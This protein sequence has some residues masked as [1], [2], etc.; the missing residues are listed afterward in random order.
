[1][2]AQPLAAAETAAQYLHLHHRSSAAFIPPPLAALPPAMAPIFHTAVGALNS[3]HA[4]EMAS[5]AAA[6]VGTAAGPGAWPQ[7][8]ASAGGARQS[9]AATAAAGAREATPGARTGAQAA[10]AAAAGPE[11]AL[12]SAGR[13]V[14]LGLSGRGTGCRAARPSP[15]SLRGG[16]G[17]LPGA[18][19]AGTP[20][21]VGGGGDAA[22]LAAAVARGLEAAMDGQGMSPAGD[23][24]GGVLGD[25]GVGFDARGGSSRGQESFGGHLDHQPASGTQDFAGAGAVGGETGVVAAAPA[26]AVPQ[27]SHSAGGAGMDVGASAGAAG[28]ASEGPSFSVGPGKENVGPG[29]EGSAAVSAGH[30]AELAVGSTPKAGPQAARPGG[31]T[32]LGVLQP[33]RA[34]QNAATAP[35]AAGPQAL[36]EV[37]AAELGLDSRAWDVAAAP[38]DWDAGVAA[39]LPTQQE[40]QAGQEPAGAHTPHG[41]STAAALRSPFALLAAADGSSGGSTPGPG[42]VA[43]GVGRVGQVGAGRYSEAGEVG[44]TEP[45]QGQGHGPEGV[46]GRGVTAARQ[47]A[48]GVGGELLPAAHS[49]GRQE[50]GE[51]QRNVT[52]GAE[53]ENAGA[54][55]MGT[56]S[57]GTQDAQQQHGND[58]AIAPA[59]GGTVAPGRWSGGSGGGVGGEAGGWCSS[60]PSSGRLLSGSATGS[61]GSDGSMLTRTLLAL[62][63]VAVA[64]A[65]AA[66]AAMGGKEQR[67]DADGAAA[68]GPSSG[69]PALQM[70]GPPGLQGS[71]REGDGDVARG[72]SVF[73]QLQQ[74]HKAGRAVGGGASQ[75]GDQ[76]T[77]PLVPT[78]E[79]PT[80]QQ[81]T[82][83]LATQLAAL[84]HT[85]QRH[86]PAGSEDA[87]AAPGGSGAGAMAVLASC[88]WGNGCGAR[89]SDLTAGK[90]RRDAARCFYDMLVLKSKGLVDLHQRKPHP[91]QQQQQMPDSRAGAEPVAAEAG[92]EAVTAGVGAAGPGGMELGL[93]VKGGAGEVGELWVTLTETGVEAASQRL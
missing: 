65:E 67:Q 89:M 23:G 56:T 86:V 10:E 55:A 27:T 58:E 26:E 44:G 32:P 11:A 49:P 64:V 87:A 81:P 71:G 75:L 48:V 88:P 68:A 24:D 60:G 84:P 38:M 74:Q 80:Q 69:L 4:L 9:G 33:S 66:V 14:S 1:M 51:E 46:A 15:A 8:A 6:A 19:G 25:G 34:Q 17:V 5:A 70:R 53:E 92:A 47:S 31:A 62:D 35:A 54:G 52:P 76:P 16:A 3:K 59:S 39:S 28:E 43:P 85:Q 13:G 21:S 45:L 22:G 91:Q 73:S 90:P 40:H 20:G 2:V 77:Q 61:G 63:H 57:P 37:V 18:E 7:P 12:G 93:R 83:L 72:L 30:A 41:V 42:T 29:E 36:P 78:Q 82:Q 79:Q 50:Q